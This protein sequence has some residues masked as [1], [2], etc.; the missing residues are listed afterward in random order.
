MITPPCARLHTRSTPQITPRP[1]PMGADS[2]ASSTA[3]TARSANRAISLAARIGRR[4]GRRGDALRIDDRRA[5]LGGVLLDHERR[6]DLAA[7]VL[8]KVERPARQQR[9]ELERGEPGAHRLAVE[10]AGLL[11]RRD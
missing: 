8:R 7:V 9:L 5:A 6:L 10:R 11:D 3:D 1:T 4:A 2:P